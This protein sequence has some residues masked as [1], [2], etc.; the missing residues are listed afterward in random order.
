M[1]KEIRNAWALLITAGVL[2][3]TVA[4]IWIGRFIGIW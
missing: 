4:I 3:I 2:G 1:N